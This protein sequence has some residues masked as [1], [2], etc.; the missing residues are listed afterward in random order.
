MA[1][2]MTKREHFQEL[3]NYV[4]VKENGY[5]VEFL[6]R[7]IELLDKKAT[8]AKMTPI[9]KDNEELKEK[10]LTYLSSL[11]EDTPSVTISQLMKV[12]GFTNRSN[13]KLSAIMRLLVLDE[14]VERTEIKRV[15]HFS[16]K[17]EEE[18]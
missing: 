4:E 10:I 14:K 3:L 1:N 6:E 17:D 9:Q 5:M 7:Q 2:K 12:E 16:L 18:S 8:N 11:S 15:A 13:Q